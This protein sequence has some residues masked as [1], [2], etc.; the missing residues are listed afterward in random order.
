MP[1][2]VIV[3]AEALSALTTP[4]SL[5]VRTVE[6]LLELNG[7]MPLDQST[8]RVLLVT[9]NGWPR[10]EKPV[11]DTESSAPINANVANR[12]T[13]IE[14]AVSVLLEDIEPVTST[15]WLLTRPVTLEA[16]PEA[17]TVIPRTMKRVP[18]SWLTGPSIVT[19]LPTAKVGATG[20]SFTSL[21][22]KVSVLP[23]AA[24]VPVGAIVERTDTKSPLANAQF[25][26]LHMV[27]ELPVVAMSTVRPLIVKLLLLAL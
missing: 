2:T 8:K 21:A 4:W 18:L 23:I 13:S 14:V 26:V 16:M 6:K 24:N 7:R 11:V 10:T 27:G 17:S 19:V 9:L 3:S 15:I 22:V 20:L 25:I 12:S 5:P 1:A